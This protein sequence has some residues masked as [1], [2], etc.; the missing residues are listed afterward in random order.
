MKPIKLSMYGFMTYK[1]KTEIDFTKLYPSRIFVISGD[2]G[3][4]K[5]SIFDAIS[6]ALFGQISRPDVDQINLRSDFLSKEDP[7]TYVNYIFEVDGRVYQIERKPSQFAKKKVRS[8][9]KINHE[10]E[11]FQIKNDKKILLSDKVGETNNLIKEIVGLDQNQ[12][13]K[14]ML[15][16]QGQFSEFLS[17]DSSTKADLLS[18][19]FQTSQYGKIQED[20]KT[21]DSTYNKDLENLDNRLEEILKKDES[22]YSSLDKARKYGHDYVNIKKLIEANLANKNHEIE[23]LS[24]KY[25]NETAKKDLLV[26]K[27]SK[28][29]A[30][31]EQINL[32]Q[33]IKEE[34]EELENRLDYYVALKESLERAKNANTIRPY[35]DRLGQIQKDKDIVAKAIEKKKLEK[36]KLE[37]LFYDLKKK[38]AGLKDIAKDLDELKIEINTYK[39]K[40]KSLDKFLTIKDSY[41]NLKSYKDE[42]N[43]IKEDQEKAD[44]SYKEVSE[45]LIEKSNKLLEIKDYKTKLVLEKTELDKKEEKNSDFIGKVNKNLEVEEK[46]KSKNEEKS[47]IEKDLHKAKFDLDQALLNQ[48]N[49]DKQK[50][51]KILNQSHICPICSTYHEEKIEEKEVFDLD[52]EAIRNNYHKLINKKSLA[53][54]EIKNL[55][56]KLIK[57][58]PK[59][60]DLNNEKKS[61]DREIIDLDH[62]LK[63]NEKELTDIDK[64]IRELENRKNKLSIATKAYDEKITL[65]SQKLG[66]FDSLERAYLLMKDQVGNLDQSL[67]KNKIKDISTKIEEKTAYIE[68]INSDFNETD[69]KLS[70]INSFLTSSM[71][72]LLSYSKSLKENT[73]IFQEKMKPYFDSNQEFLENLKSFD[74]LNNKQKEIEDFFDAYKTVDIRLSSLSSYKDL[75]V[76]DINQLDE[77][78]KVI[79]ENILKFTETLAKEKINQLNLNS[80]LSEVIDIEKSYKEKAWVGQI[81]GRLAKIASGGY[82]SIKG[83]EK[84]DFETFVL[85]YY[86]EKILAYSNKRLFAMSNGQ[87]RMIRK[88]SGGDMRSK[89]GLDI[90]IIDANTGK[91][92]PASTLSG[93]ETFLT[94]LSLA[95]GLSDE[96]SAENGGIKID[97]LFIDEGFGSLSDNYLE[98]A[99]NTIEKLS[100]EN[101]FIGL[102][103]HVKEVKDSIDAKILVKYDKSQGS[104][105]EIII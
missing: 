62:K 33:K 97:T 90:E 100:Y 103:S 74:Q 80:T 44:H 98:N 31:N 79:N 65:L 14:V 64:S 82:G 4:G 51:I 30:E 21:L 20:L 105:V 11:L 13:K 42:L 95:L 28:A 77:K 3:S 61:L 45:K 68:A 84:L 5:T 34:K 101:K 26:D 43:K 72:N 53:E 37:L 15:L 17:A 81:I 39:D 24:I 32:Y 58:L 88:T 78:L 86:F 56:E 27:I 9:V 67:I 96:I 18:D 49:I 69:K 91:S 92:R 52:L 23:D 59:L 47:L 104:E 48:E 99:I 50:Y 40:E 8:G 35:Y 87:Y 70:E 94:S 41:L 7:P 89:Q 19:I 36:K 75:K 25:K 29:E 2:T 73:E 60:D 55:K 10:V 54:N 71:D 38:K 6:F 46:I 85:I 102:I 63:A 16:A 93:G 22:I 12:L 76:H 1:K 83:R 66:E 57:D